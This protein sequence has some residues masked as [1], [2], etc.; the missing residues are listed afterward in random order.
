MTAATEGQAAGVW[1]SRITGVVAPNKDF[2]NGYHLC[3]TIMST[4]KIN[5]QWA[6]EEIR[7]KKIRTG[8]ITN[9]QQFAENTIN[10]KF[11]QM[12]ATK[13][14]SSQRWSDIILGSNQVQNNGTCDIYTT[15]DLAY[16]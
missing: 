12:N 1:F 14:Q 6:N 5:A 4:F 2:Q 16:W 11:A 15:N 7:Q 13:D 9:L 8:I 3:G 10:Q